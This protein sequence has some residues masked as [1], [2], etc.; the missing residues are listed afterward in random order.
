LSNSFPFRGL[1]GPDLSS[2]SQGHDQNIGRLE[3][4]WLGDRDGFIVIM[5]DDRPNKSSVIQKNQNMPPGIGMV[6]ILP[7][8]GNLCVVFIV[9]MLVVTLMP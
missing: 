6:H 2:K 7:I 5:A 4:T 1:Q 8:L 3:Q 9:V